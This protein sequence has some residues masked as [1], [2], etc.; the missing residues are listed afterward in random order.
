MLLQLKEDYPVPQPKRGELL[1]KLNMTGL[2]M[3]GT[4]SD[5]I[6]W[7]ASI[8][9]ADLQTITLWQVIDVTLLGSRTAGSSNYGVWLGM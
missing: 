5:P 1:L 9:N 2:C 7:D 3:S 4:S 6:A 8:T